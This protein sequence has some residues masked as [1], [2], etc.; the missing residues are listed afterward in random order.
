MDLCDFSLKS[1][2]EA[3]FIT[4]FR[5]SS[6]FIRSLSLILAAI[7]VPEDLHFDSGFESNG[8]FGEGSGKTYFRTDWT[9]RSW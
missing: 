8:G 9:K 7:S 4:E 1:I 6:L 3:D 2:F 5:S